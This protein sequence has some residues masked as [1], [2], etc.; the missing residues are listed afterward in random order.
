[1]RKFTKV[2]VAVAAAITLSTASAEAQQTGNILAKADVLQAIT[3]SF[4]QDLDFGSVLP[5]V[6]SAVDA[7]TNPNAGRWDLSGYN[8]PG[9]NVNI[10]FSA[11]PAS[12]TGPGVPIPVGSWTGCWIAGAASQVG[13]TPF[14]PSAAATATSLS[15]GLMSVYIGNDITPAANQAPG[16]YQGTI[17]LDAAYF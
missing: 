14:V 3:V 7:A 9:A 17:T 15:G 13:C 10:S 4:G 1:M 11:L 2:A 5:G 16:L 12:L 8:G 6:T